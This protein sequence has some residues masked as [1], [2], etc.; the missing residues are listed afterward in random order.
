MSV[1]TN[2]LSTYRQYPKKLP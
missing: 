1:P 2:K